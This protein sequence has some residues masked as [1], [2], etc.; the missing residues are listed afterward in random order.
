MIEPEVKTGKKRGRKLGGSV[1]HSGLCVAARAL[2]VTA[3]HLLRVIEGTRPSAKLRAQYDA[4][5]V[6]NS[7]LNAAQRQATEPQEPKEKSAA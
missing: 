5:M 6:R 4:L 7:Q 1:R 3:G 2:G